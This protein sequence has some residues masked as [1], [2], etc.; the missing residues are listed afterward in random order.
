ME[1]DKIKTLISEEDVAHN[2]VT[3]KT[4]DAL[5]GMV[6][7]VEEEP[8][9][10]VAAAKDEDKEKEKKPRTRRTKKAEAADEAAAE[11]KDGEA[12]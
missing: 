4:I 5:L 10:E 3:N 12:K 6:N 9:Q 7:F 11:A 2:V 8:K 1:V